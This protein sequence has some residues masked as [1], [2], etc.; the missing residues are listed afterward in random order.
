MGGAFT[1]LLWSLSQ[2]YTTG[3]HFPLG[4]RFL[5]RK[6]CLG[7][8]SEH[9]AHGQTGMKT[10]VIFL[11]ALLSQGRP[12]S[13]ATRSV[14]LRSLSVSLLPPLFT[15]HIRP[16]LLTFKNFL[17]ESAN[18]YI[19]FETLFIKPRAPFQSCTE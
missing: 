17:F 10:S 8:N 1:T 6:L 18:L 19:I 5:P 7:C 2:I 15:D 16:L 13:S 3:S 11:T 12:Q 9:N 4:K 14:Q